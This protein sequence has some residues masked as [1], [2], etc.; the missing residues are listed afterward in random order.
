MWPWAIKA[1]ADLKPKVML[2]E[3]VPNLARGHKAYFDY[4]LKALALPTIADPDNWANGDGE[5]LAKV[6]ESGQ[7]F[8]PSY[9]ITTTTLLA[10]D[11]GTAQKRKRLFIVGVR[12]DLA[13]EF[14]GPESTHSANELM[15]DKWITGEYWDR[16]GLE[17][18]IMDEAG[19]RWIRKHNQQAPDLF[20]AKLAAHRTVRDAF[21]TI[22][23]KA[24]N[25]EPAPRKAKA[26]KGHTGSPIDEPSK[27]LR[28]GDH[29]VSG[30]E[31][32]VA[33]SID[34]KPSYEHFS[35]R[36][37]A[38]ISGF[39]EDYEF[40]GNWSDGLKQLGNAVPVEMGRA[41]GQSLHNTLRRAA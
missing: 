11:H 4:L 41:M 30:G 16:H 28:A 12:Q 32:M 3:N 15:H 6:L 39:P 22:S 36:Q 21:S 20:A 40:S 34:G 38:A 2:W 13:A 10:A 7:S 37:A 26:Y 9:H 24:A 5:R 25:N 29:G 23:P 1:A 31:N 14:I 18:P 33:Y 19:L 35:V 8:D 27:T 17:R